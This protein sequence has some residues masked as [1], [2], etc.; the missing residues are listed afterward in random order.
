[1]KDLV[2]SVTDSIP[3]NPLL[4]VPVEDIPLLKEIAKGKLDNNIKI[5][6]AL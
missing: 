2:Y 1:M 3:S 5:K 6:S 4:S